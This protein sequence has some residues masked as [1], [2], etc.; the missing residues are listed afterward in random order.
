MDSNALTRCF[1]IYLYCCPCRSFRRG[2]TLKIATAAC[3]FA[4]EA[5]I[6][7]QVA[8]L[9]QQS[10][11]G[12]QHCSMGK[13]HLQLKRF[14]TLSNGG[15]CVLRKRRAEMRCTRRIAFF[16][17]WWR[18]SYKTHRS[19]LGQVGLLSSFTTLSADTSGPSS[20]FPSAVSAFCSRNRSEVS[21]RSAPRSSRSHRHICM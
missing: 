1:R 12:L 16:H 4:T 13:E 19:W 15:P 2:Y 9:M 3:S 21:H 14:R 5:F 8:T 18:M 11:S 20:P 10:P 6:S 7:S 17:A